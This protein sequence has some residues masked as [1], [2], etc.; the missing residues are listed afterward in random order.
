MIKIKKGKSPAYLLGDTVKK[1]IQKA[2][3]EKNNHDFQTYYY[4][5]KK[6][7]KPVLET[8]YHNKCCYCERDEAGGVELQVEHFRPKKT[9][10]ECKDSENH[11]GYYWLG[12]EW[13]NLLLSCSTCN[14]YKGNSFPIENKIRENEPTLN[15]NRELIIETCKPDNVPLVNEK[16]LLFNPD[17]DNAF[18]HF[19][20]ETN[21]Y[22]TSDTQKG[23]KT[24]DLLKLNDTPLLTA[25]NR[26]INDFIESLNKHLFAFRKKKINKK[27]LRYY[28]SETFTRLKHKNS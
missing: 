21:G 22:I 10:K 20:F 28:F 6:E 5:N 1:R 24:I 11:F 26:I 19:E 15:E 27:G 25:R 16:T 8:I 14:K 18:E 4:G 7:V 9:P 17:I 12:Y 3:D 13:S 23:Q 2:L